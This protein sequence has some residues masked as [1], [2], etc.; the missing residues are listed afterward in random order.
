MTG[1]ASSHSTAQFYP[2]GTMDSGVSS[3]ISPFL[4]LPTVLF[5][6]PQSLSSSPVFSLQSYRENQ[7]VSKIPFSLRNTFVFDWPGKPPVERRTKRIRISVQLCTVDALIERAGPDVCTA[8]GGKR[9]YVLCRIF[10]RSRE[11]TN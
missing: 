4:V 2:S 10:K 6:F 1:M 8:S 7:F 3:C 9:R 5:I 11:K